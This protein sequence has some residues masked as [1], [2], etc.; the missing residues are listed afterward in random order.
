MLLSGLNVEKKNLEFT[1]SKKKQRDEKRKTGRQRGR[2][3][4]KKK[5]DYKVFI[6]GSNSLNIFIY[7]ALFPLSIQSFQLSAIH[8]KPA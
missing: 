7:V 8:F 5:A 3:K 2:D 4:E 6:Y 1:V